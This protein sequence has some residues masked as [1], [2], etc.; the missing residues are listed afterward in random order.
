M[1]AQTLPAM[2]MDQAARQGARA[3]VQA[4]GGTLEYGE[5]P[6]HAARWAALLAA[7]GVR[8]GDRV[9]LMAGN[10]IEFLS[11]V[12]GCGWLGAVAVPINTASRGMQLRHILE[13]SACVLLVADAASCAGLATVDG[14]GLALREIWLLDGDAP[15]AGLALPAPARAAPAAPPEGVEPADLGPGDML[16]ILYTSGTSGLSKG[17]CCPHAQFWW[18]GLIAA[19]NL[20]IRGEDV[21]YTSLPL[22]HTNALNA[23]FQALVTGA[24]IVCDE[25]FSVS[26]YFDRLE[27]TGATV[28]YL[29]GAMVPMLLAREPAPAERRH[30]ARIALA[31]GVPERFHGEFL[32][33]TGLALLE[34]YGSTE[35]NFALGGV[36]AEQ[37]P[38]TM[39]RVAPEFEAC[40]ADEHDAPVP[41]GQPGELLLRARPPY[42]IATGYFAMADKTVEAWRNLWFHTGDRVVRDADGYYRFLDRMKDAIRRRGENISSYEVE[43]V[44]LAHPAIAAVAVYAVQSELAEDEVMAALVY[45]P[46]SK[47]A[48]AELLDFCQPRMP[49]F[50]VPRYL[51]AM[52]EL[53]RTENGKIRKFKLRDEGVTADTWDRDK[54]GYKVSR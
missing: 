19:R 26:R 34:G 49:Y 23:C 5:A 20:E 24:S 9:A 14:D 15:P 21:L 50:A 29:L 38:G 4:P 8:R 22:F 10:R 40:V 17:V 39:G 51:R 32:R 30:R 28:T 47:V 52:E 35:T 45:K 18:W 33:R 12:L 6:A 41:D 31:P 43:Q 16:A 11:V 37:R 44:L 7:H 13:N 48:H 1:H 46:G 53:P 3:W 36:L 54:A 2:L 42:A 27:Q 25:R